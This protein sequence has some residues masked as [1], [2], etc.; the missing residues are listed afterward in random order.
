MRYISDYQQR[1]YDQ[2]IDVALISG[3]EKPTLIIKD[4]T[5]S[6]FFW[7]LPTVFKTDITGTRHTV[8]EF[9]YW[10]PDSP[11]MVVNQVHE[12]LNYFRT[13]FDQFKRLE[14]QMRTNEHAI[15]RAKNLDGVINAS[16]YPTW[17]NHFQTNKFVYTFES[18]QFNSLLL[19]FIHTEKFAKVY[20][21][22]YFNDALAI[23]PTL[24]HHPTYKDRGKNFTK[25]YPVISL[26]KF[27]QGVRW[28]G[29]R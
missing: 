8:I 13:N 28:N 19:P 11:Y 6:A 9:F 21:H 27:Y 1:L 20:H 22:R 23:D 4:E 29:T 10:T 7:D 26:Q 14:H 5:L 17:G 24:I 25:T 15:D 2:G 18:N 16:C 12:L 3:I